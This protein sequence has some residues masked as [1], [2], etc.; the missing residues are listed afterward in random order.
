MF[1]LVNVF[2]VFLP[3]LLLYPNPADPLNRLAAQL[4]MKDPKTY[5]Q[6]V[7]EHVQLHAS[8]DFKMNA[9][10]EEDEGEGVEEGQG[11]TGVD[12]EG[13]RDSGG[14]EGGSAGGDEGMEDEEG[15]VNADEEDEV[16]SDCDDLPTD[17][18]ADQ[19]E[20]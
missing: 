20:L 11:D 3:Q 10:D 17:D 12:G 14:E 4:L 13:G 6:R 9:D 2:N 15:E 16:L 18:P 7:H 1:D 8:K 5:Q 19:L